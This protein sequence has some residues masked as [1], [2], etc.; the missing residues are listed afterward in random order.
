[1]DDEDLTADRHALKDRRAPTAAYDRCQKSGPLS[2]KSQLVSIILPNNR[3]PHGRR[4][5]PRQL[6]RMIR[7]GSGF[8]LTHWRHIS[9]SMAIVGHVSSKE[10]GRT[11]PEVHGELQGGRSSVRGLSQSQSGRSMRG[12]L[13]LLWSSSGDAEITLPQSCQWHCPFGRNCISS[14]FG[15]MRVAVV[16]YCSCARRLLSCCGENIRW[17]RI[18]DE[19]QIPEFRL[20]NATE[21]RFKVELVRSYAYKTN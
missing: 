14:G 19:W 13:H 4:A 2:A 18:A 7:D 12:R 21:A 10:R 1:V 3:V 16:A 8:G 11:A 17:P 5:L 15:W 20:S 9:L 6:G